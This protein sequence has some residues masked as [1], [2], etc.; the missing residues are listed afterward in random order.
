LFGRGILSGAVVEGARNQNKLAPR[1]QRFAAA[2]LIKALIRPAPAWRWSCAGRCA[3]RPTRVSHTTTAAA[4]ASQGSRHREVGE[5]VAR[6]TSNAAGAES[7]RQPVKLATS[8]ATR[9]HDRGPGWRGGASRALVRQTLSR[10]RP[11]VVV[12]GWHPADN[13]IAAPGRARDGSTGRLAQQCTGEPAAARFARPLG[14]KYQLVVFS[15]IH[16]QARLIDS[17]R[18]F[19]K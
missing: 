16:S 2:T 19:G 9:P 5:T 7:F 4:G 11:V 8:S 17:L 3:P 15:S 13:Q 10:I 1:R 14:C 12:F 18:K 6:A